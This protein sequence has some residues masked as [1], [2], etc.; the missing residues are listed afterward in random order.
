MKY[1]LLNNFVFN[2]LKSVLITLLQ[3][4]TTANTIFVFDE[5]KEKQKG[6]V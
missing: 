6:I 3:I 2:N 4:N 5:T 1:L